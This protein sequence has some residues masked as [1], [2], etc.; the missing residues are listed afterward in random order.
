MVLIL[1][2]PFQLALIADEMGLGKAVHSIA[3]M[4]TYASEWT[5]LMLSPSSA[6]FNW[7]AEWLQWVARSEERASHEALIDESEI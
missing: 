5:L 3:S 6:R 2:V 4:T 1:L 7:K